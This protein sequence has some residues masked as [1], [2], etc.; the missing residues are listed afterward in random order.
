[1][2]EIVTAHLNPREAEGGE[3]P[4]IHHKRTLVADPSL[5]SP[6][7]SRIPALGSVCWFPRPA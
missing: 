2:T 7:L 3:G 6:R 1:M 5:S 4:E